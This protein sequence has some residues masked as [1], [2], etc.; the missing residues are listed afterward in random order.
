MWCK[1]WGSLNTLGPVENR[2]PASLSGMLT[3][4][5]K[6]VL[7][8]FCKLMIYWHIFAGVCIPSHLSAITNYS[9]K[10]TLVLWHPSDFP[11][12]NA[13]ILEPFHEM[14]WPWRNEDD[15]NRKGKII[16]NCKW[17]HPFKFSPPTLNHECPIFYGLSTMKNIGT[18]KLFWVRVLWKMT[19]VETA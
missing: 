19:S 12:K 2:W 16:I 17:D 11:L 7:S 1:R 9:L 6:W 15:K 13:R 14:H 4:E 5:G 3:S 10:N 18:R 8:G